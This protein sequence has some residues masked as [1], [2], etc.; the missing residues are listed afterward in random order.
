MIKKDN[1]RFPRFLLELKCLS[2]EKHYLLFLFPLAIR[3]SLALPCIL[4][5]YMFN[6]ENV[7]MTIIIRRFPNIDGRL[8]KTSHT[9]S[10]HISLFYLIL[11]HV[12]IQ[13]VD[14]FLVPSQLFSPLPLL[15]LSLRNTWNGYMHYNLFL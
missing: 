14:I 10:V 4:L 11:F 8:P 2:L 9:F 13:N 6:N 3:L 12:T 5:K 1:Q 15:V 7:I